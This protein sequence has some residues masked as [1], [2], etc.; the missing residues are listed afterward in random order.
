MLG[1]DAGVECQIGLAHG[2]AMA[3]AAQEVADRVDFEPCGLAD[4]RIH[5][6]IMRTA[7]GAVNSK[8]PCRFGRSRLHKKAHRALN[9]PVGRYDAYCVGDGHIEPVKGWLCTRRLE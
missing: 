3:P 6:P 1:R 8:L 4:R 5:P 7:R 2:A 9:Q